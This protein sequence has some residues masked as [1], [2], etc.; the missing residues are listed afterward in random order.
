MHR[1]QLKR[2]AFAAHVKHCRSV[3]IYR[4]ISQP[5]LAAVSAGV[6]CR[7]AQ[8]T[9]PQPR[10]VRAHPPLT[11]RDRG[12]RTRNDD[13]S[14]RRAIAEQMGVGHGH[15][16]PQKSY[17]CFV[18]LLGE[19]G[20]FN[21]ERIWMTREQRDTA[22]LRNCR[23][24]DAKS[25]LSRQ[26]VKFFEAEEICYQDY[27]C[28]D[29]AQCRQRKARLER[30][31]SVAEWHLYWYS[32][33]EVKKGRLEPFQLFDDCMCSWRNSKR[34][35]LTYQVM[36]C[37]GR[38][39][40]AT[41]YRVHVESCVPKISK[42]FIE[43]VN[44]ATI[45][46]I[47]GVFRVHVF[48]VAPIFVPGYPHACP[49]FEPEGSYAHV[50]AGVTRKSKQINTFQPTGDAGRAY[51]L[52]PKGRRGRHLPRSIDMTRA[53][54]GGRPAP[55]RARARDVAPRALLADRIGRASRCGCAAASSYGLDL[56]H[57]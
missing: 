55:L 10:P 51:V 45:F 56:L 29:T 6:A 20:I 44:T 5:A 3:I 22:G 15:S 31:T 12:R 39:G 46:I 26:L 13:C 24:P 18:C 7:H 34:V 53:A 2:R 32:T 43:L 9:T 54:A 28:V 49:R 40:A 38:S 35:L 52:S 4:P 41:A 14:L 1:H 8:L 17:H 37:A 16:Q 36:E 19:Y 42:T 27:N 11:V 33:G 48:G 50:F 23:S 30:L 21:E 57:L 25:Q 47:N